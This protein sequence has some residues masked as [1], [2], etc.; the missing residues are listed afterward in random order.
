M[1]MTFSEAERK[2][3]SKRLLVQP[4]PS[5]DAV[6]QHRLI[7]D[8]LKRIEGLPIDVLETLEAI[9]LL[10]EQG[11]EVAK[12]LYD[13]EREKLGIDRPRHFGL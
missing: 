5:L 9:R 8:Q 10:A 7:H 13:T 11:N 6:R 1:P 2:A 3:L 4:P 12:D